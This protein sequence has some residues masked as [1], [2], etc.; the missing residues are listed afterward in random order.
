VD[1][2]EDLSG[3]GNNLQQSGTARPT[4]VTNATNSRAALNFDGSDDFMEFDNRIAT[5]DFSYA[6]V[7]SREKIPW[8]KFLFQ[9]DKHALIADVSSS[10]HYGVGL[11]YSGKYL[12]SSS[13]SNNIYAITSGQVSGASTAVSLGKNSNYSIKTREALNNFNVNSSIAKQNNGRLKGKIVEIIF[14]NVVL[15]SAERKII[16]SYLAAKYNRNIT[17]DKYAY[18]GNYGHGVIGIGQESDG[19]NTEAK[20]KGRLLISNASSLDN[21][22]YLLTGHNNLGFGT[23]TSVSPSTLERWDQVWRAD[24]TGSAGSISVEFFIGN[25]TFSANTSNY[26]VLVDTVDGDFTNGGTF[27]HET[28]RLYDNGSNSISFDNLNLKDGAYFTLAEKKATIS[29]INDGDWSDPNTWDCNCHPSIDDLV[30][31]GTSVTISTNESV[32]NLVIEASGTL[33]FTGSDTLFIHGDWQHAG[34]LNAG[35]GTVAA[36]KPTTVQTF[37]NSSSQRVDFHNLYVN[38]DEGLELNSGGWSVSN[39]LQVLNSSI[40]VSAADSIVLLSNASSTSQILP[41]K[42]NAYIGNFI[43]QRYISS[44]SSSWANF[45]SPV[46]NAT[47]ADWDDD[48]YMSG[49]NGND[50][51]VY[52]P[53]SSIYYTVFTY[54]HQQDKHDT[55]SNT[56]TSLEPCKGYELWLAD[57]AYNYYGG[58]IDVIGTPNTGFFRKTVTDGWNFFGNPYH[59]YISYDSLQ[60]TIWVPDN[61]YIWNTDNGNYEFFNGASKPPIASG[62]GFWINHSGANKYFDFDEN[63]KVDN[64]SSAF[65]RKKQKQTFALNLSSTAVTY[66]HKMEVDFSPF[67]SDEIDEK[68]AYYLK[69]RIEEAPAITTKATN[70]E[71]EL[72]YNSLNPTEES[73]LVPV[74]IYAGVEG[75]YTINAANLDALYNNYSCVYLKDKDTEEAVDLMV[76]PNY[77]FEAKQG[78]ADRFHLI[79]SNSYEQ[80]QEM[81]K[82]GEFNQKLDTK[83]SLRNAYEQWYLDYTL[84]EAQTQ[85]EVRIYNM[86]GQEVKAPQS[87]EA[88]G[89]GTYPLQ[90]LND[91]D[92]IYLIQVVGKDVFLNKQ[93]KL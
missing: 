79:L 82:N 89:A 30:I 83:V 19:S 47:I 14:Y 41:S 17:N 66:Q 87:F 16:D 55:V 29:S 88:N 70:S 24:K 85:L 49:V 59:S 58:T 75:D 52:Y 34:F 72:I 18:D 38:N 67:S 56:S 65:L 76:E 73:Q 5:A 61:F 39:N 78:K 60:K 48:L 20:G 92:G 21:G 46:N 54:N 42:N 51:N 57:D 2:W 13:L 11:E 9:T 26:V 90:N 27:E 12:H 81:I 22:D 8:K 33:N 69:S 7:F 63:A 36:V 23:N 28:G 71:E 44:R 1:L 31:T 3:N 15:N 50:G 37:N 86:S 68:D 84:G 62:Q 80:C 77:T 74:S 64:N 91:L 25:D 40:D 6:V 53:D 32:R 93:V 45:S 43:I 4:Y 35:S 10:N